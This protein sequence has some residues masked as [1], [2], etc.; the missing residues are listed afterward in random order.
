M[1]RAVA[2]G[3]RWTPSNQVV[4]DDWWKLGAAARAGVARAPPQSNRRGVPGS[5]KRPLIS[6]ASTMR[7][8]LR[9]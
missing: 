5:A 3:T 4:T 8:S 7:W 6:D 2:A 1:R 9:W